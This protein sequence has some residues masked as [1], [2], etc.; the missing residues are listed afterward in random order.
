MITAAIGSLSPTG[1]QKYFTYLAV[2]PVSCA[3]GLSLHTCWCALPLALSCIW[4][5]QVWTSLYICS[6][7][8]HRQA[9]NK[10]CPPLCRA[11]NHSIEPLST[12]VMQAWFTYLFT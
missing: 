10:K 4:R 9:S 6:F 8:S 1:S 11:L 7:P 3:L 2:A 5:L 12:L